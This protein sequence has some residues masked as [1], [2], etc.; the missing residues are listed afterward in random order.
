MEWSSIQSPNRQT[1]L[2]AC[3]NWN[4]QESSLQD[5]EREREI[6][7][8]RQSWGFAG[9]G[10]RMRESRRGDL[11][12]AEC[13]WESEG[14]AGCGIGI[15]WLRNAESLPSLGVSAVRTCERE[16]ERKLNNKKPRWLRFSPE[17]KTETEPTL[18]V[19]YFFST[20][21][22]SSVRFSVFR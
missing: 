4:A 19:G 18:R 14:F 2:A 9:C 6:Q 10:M 16:N 8:M 12:A 17:V 5:C 22:V 15:C 1:V 3:E 20:V 21:G 13:G 11:L 7:R